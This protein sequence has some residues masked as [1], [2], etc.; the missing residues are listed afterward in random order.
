MP[1]S[2][3]ESEVT[4]GT[5]TE[6]GVPPP[7]LRVVP[8]RTGPCVY[9]LTSGGGLRYVGSTVEFCARQ[10]SH[11]IEGRKVWDAAVCLL[12]ERGRVV[13]LEEALIALLRPPDNRQS[14]PLT[15]GRLLIVE[16]E[17]RARG[18]PRVRRE[19]GAEP[20]VGVFAS[21]ALWLA[22]AGVDVGDAPR[23]R[24][25]GEPERRSGGRRP[26]WS[27][28][29]VYARDRFGIERGRD[30]RVEDLGTLEALA[31]RGLAPGER[32]RGVADLLGEV[33]DRGLEV[34]RAELGLGIERGAP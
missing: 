34:V 18:V 25:A 14:L 26:R 10:G 29:G 9:F 33:L 27:M 30:L 15:P 16:E 8:F 28:V 22:G 11:V 23:P 13:P 7:F 32:V 21:V 2:V 17:L 1:G 12:L 5:S 4:D 3:R 24:L 31:R 6:S 20:W 19:R